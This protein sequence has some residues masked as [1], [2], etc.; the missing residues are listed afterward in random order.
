MANLSHTPLTFRQKCAYS[1][2]QIAI[3]VMGV[4]TAQW[5]TFFYR[6]AEA[7][8]R[9]ALIGAATFAALMLLGRIVDG[10]ADPAIGYWSDRTK[11]RWGRR[12][13]FIVL[14]TPAL[15]L[16]FLIL[17]FP[18]DVSATVANA[19]YL[20]AGL[21]F[22]WIAFTIVVGPYYALLPE[23][24]VS[25]RERVRLSSVMMVFVAV[26]TI[27]AVLIG[28]VQSAYPDGAVIAGVHIRSG[29]QLFAIGASIA[30]FISFV[31]MPLGIREEV[32][33]RAPM[34]GSL[35]Q[36]VRSTF[37]NRAF[38]AYLG[39]AVFVPLGL[40]VFGGGLPYFC[41]VV[42]EV[43][44]DEVGLIKD[45]QG[46]AW[47]GTY[48]AVLFVV[49]LLSLPVVNFLSERISKKKLMIW[50]GLVFAAGLLFVPASLLFEDPA[51]VLLV[52]VAILGF[53]TAVALILA[54]AIAAEV[55][56]YDEELTGMRRE[57]LYA[58][59]SALVAKSIQGLA[60]AI[61]VGL[62]VLGTTHDNPRGIVL[63]APAAGVLVII[64]IAIFS[65]TP[66]ET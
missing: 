56:D 47:T 43:G 8:G 7:E 41:T 46:E 35:F 9:P 2:P 37:E 20:G 64:G 40:Q 26:G 3:N 49:A 33:E 5:L 61:I 58:G 55:V 10:V 6:P 28:P 14:G 18:P 36:N 4:M 66:I 48:M 42:L 59:A 22:Y 17:W 54:N 63:A 34:E 44:P 57:G 29:I 30:V 60:P 45:G 13:P 19:V 23:I 38:V 51:L 50:S 65:R 32:R 15:A 27:G 11:S 16:S 12:M 1:V 24:A 52:V 31:L 25:N 21:A 39:M 62:H 53:P